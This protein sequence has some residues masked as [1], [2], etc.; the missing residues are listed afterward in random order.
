MNTDEILEER[1]GDYGEYKYQVK[2]IAKIMD[3]L[4][5]LRALNDVNNQNIVTGDLEFIDEMDV[6]NFFLVLK[7]C[8]M[9]TSP[10][11]EDNYTDL[12]GYTKLIKERRC[13][14]NQE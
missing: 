3:E 5:L 13:R 9:Q 7:L 6:E 10:K 11:K 4:A 2:A 12:E 14:Q 1:K 8:R